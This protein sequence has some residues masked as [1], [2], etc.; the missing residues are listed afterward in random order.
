MKGFLRNY[1]QIVHVDPA[2][3]I[4]ALSQADSS[5]SQK[6]EYRFPVQAL[7]PKMASSMMAL[8]IVLFCA[9][10]ICVL[11]NGNK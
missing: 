10:G 3:L 1:C 2:P 4:E 5:V 8:I 6:P 11:G 7:V 9:W